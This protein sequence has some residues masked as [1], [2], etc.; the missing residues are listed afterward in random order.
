MRIHLLSDLHLG[1]AP[2]D[3]PQVQADL[4]VLA[5]DIHRPAATLEWLKGVEIPIVYVLGNHEFYGSSFSETYQFLAQ[6]KT[7]LPNLHWLQNSSLELNGVRILGTSL[8]TDFLIY[9]PNE[10]ELSKIDEESMRF[11]RDFSRITYT[12]GQLFTPADARAEFAANLAWLKEQLNTPFAGKTLVVTHHAPSALSIES[13]FA[14][15]PLNANFVSNL[16]DIMGKEKIDLWLH[17]HTHASFDYQIKGT[18]VVCNPRGY[19]KDLIP[20][21]PTF[22]PELV[23]SL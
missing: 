19:A 18:R 22:N 17:G 13:R 4:L 16:E 21:N 15:S 5:G 11:N 3:L 10:E 6:A 1:Y 7:Q 23:L 2:M 20:E 12:S 9:Q 14:G 8:W